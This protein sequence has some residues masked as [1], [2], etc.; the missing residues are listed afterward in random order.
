MQER[1]SGFLAGL[2]S[3]RDELR[4]RCRTILQSRAEELAQASRTDSRYT[5]MQIPP[6]LWFS[7]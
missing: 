2:A 5:Q 3:R 1:V 6:W 4:C 7:N